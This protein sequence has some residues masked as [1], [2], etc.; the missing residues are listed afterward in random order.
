MAFLAPLSVNLFA[1]FLNH[2]SFAV[3]LLL[4]PLS[5]QSVTSKHL[6]VL[7]RALRSPSAA[8]VNAPAWS[9]YSPRTS[10]NTPDCLL[11]IPWTHHKLPTI[12][13]ASLRCLLNFAA[14]IVFRTLGTSISCHSNYCQMVATCM[15]EGG[16]E[17][18][19]TEEV[20][21][22]Q[23]KYQLLILLCDRNI[24]GCRSFDFNQ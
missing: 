2:S 9:M 3:S 17:G 22:A 1:W 7:F 15:L 11:S 6:P 20:V 18:W 14:G 19:W 13:S 10:G 21:V 4:S 8:Y 12:C 5:L 16:E 24:W 23:R